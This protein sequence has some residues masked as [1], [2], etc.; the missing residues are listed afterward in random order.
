MYK[1]KSVCAV[2]PA[3]NEWTQIGRVIETMPDFVDKI[4][5]VDDLSTDGTAEV[6]KF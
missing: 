1:D 6:V 5:I 4:V 3:Y 2:I